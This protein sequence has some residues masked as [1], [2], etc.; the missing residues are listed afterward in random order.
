MD[1]QTQIKKICK[2]TL[3]ISLTSFLLVGCKNATEG[4]APGLENN[5]PVPE[6]P[7]PEI[8]VSPAVSFL[9]NGTTVNSANGWNL[10]IDTTDAVISHTTLNGW[11]IE[12]K[13][14]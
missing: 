11:K 1:E 2:L 5:N 9:K 7:S 14:E 3:V 4:F 10:Q 13:Y 6:S 8:P 12:V